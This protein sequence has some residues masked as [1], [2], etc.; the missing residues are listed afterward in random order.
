VSHLA[1]TKMAHLA[2]TKVCCTA[3]R[4]QLRVCGLPHSNAHMQAAPQ[5]AQAQPFPTGGH[6]A[7]LCPRPLTCGLAL[8]VPS[9]ALG[10]R[11]M[12][13][14]AQ[15]S[16]RMPMQHAHFTVAAAHTV[17][18][19][20]THAAPR[21]HPIPPQPGQAVHGRAATPRRVSFCTRTRSRAH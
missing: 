18:Q 12:Q 20:P 3:L 14:R 13:A 19:R 21:S 6:R 2:G 9:H 11:S 17:Q 1:S 10:H 4:R 8:H 5:C 15:G 7:P 16:Q